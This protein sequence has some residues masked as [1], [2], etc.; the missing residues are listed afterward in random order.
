MLNRI[1][2]QIFLILPI[3]QVQDCFNTLQE[4]THTRFNIQNFIGTNN[5]YGE[6]NNYYI[7]VTIYRFVPLRLF[8]TDW[9]IGG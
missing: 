6:V 7:Y 8:R 9:M 2:L 3:T 5:T 1:Y 4:T